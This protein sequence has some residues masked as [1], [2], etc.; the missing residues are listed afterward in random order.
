MVIV[1]FN[2]YVVDSNGCVGLINNV[3]VIAELIIIWFIIEHVVCVISVF[4]IKLLV[5]N[6]Y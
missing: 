4:I 2:V 5:A 1:I 3:I 6:W